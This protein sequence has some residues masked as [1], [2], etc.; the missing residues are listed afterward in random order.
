MKLKWIIQSDGTK[1]L[2]VIRD[3]IPESLP[4]R[5]I[6]NNTITSTQDILTRTEQIYIPP[7]NIM[8][9]LCHVSKNLFNQANYIVKQELDK[10]NKWIRYND[11]NRQ[12][13]NTENYTTLHA[14]SSQSILKRLDESWDSFFTAIKDW[15][16]NPNKYLGRPKPPHYKDKN[17]QHIL[18]FTNQQCRLMR[19]KEKQ[20]L[21][22]FPNWTKIPDIK[23]RL[24]LDTNLR[25]VRIIPK[26]VGYTC[27]I[28]Y[29][30]KRDD[31]R[32]NKLNL[33]KDR[34]I[35]IDTGLRNVVAISNNIEIK[36]IIIKGSVLKSINQ[37]YNKRRAEIQSVY[38]RQPIMCRLSDH[39]VL[40]RMTGKAI[41]K[42]TEDRNNKIKDVMHKYSRYIIDYC[43]TNKVGTIVIGVNDLWKQK[44]TLGKIN[45]QNFVTI[46]FYIL[47]NQIKYKASEFGIRVI[48]QNEA[49]T[50]KC[51]FLDNEPIEHRD[52]YAGKRIKRGIF[53]SAK[54]IW[55]NAD[56]NG[57][58]NIIKKA[59]PNAFSGQLETKADGIEGVIS[60]GLHP[61]RV[62]PLVTKRN[63][64]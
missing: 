62:N 46:P 45:N 14:Q 52:S 54:N 27:E 11:L 25:E 44:I 20:N 48:E 56:V 15:K 21:L 19:N 23:I 63:D 36:P 24:T 34:I 42:L 4:R 61:L 28:V 47:R 57:S 59:I 22:T 9:N 38:N 5:K 3:V 1:K 7:N 58:L 30:K 53:K 6:D 49:H 26:G 40:C 43:L 18:I 31:E 12:L 17:G 39:K 64:L 50:S 8:S 41:K 60:Y 29:D 33:D 35:G 55:I 37:F 13:K 32:I 51:S 2:E 10:T 16:I